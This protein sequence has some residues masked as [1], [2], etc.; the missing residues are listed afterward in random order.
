[1]A[2]FN[3]TDLLVFVDGNAVAHSN[4]CTITINQNQVDATDKDSS[5]WDEFI[6]GQR[7]WTVDVDGLV[8]YSTSVNANE[9]FDDAITA[10]ASVT[11]IFSTAVSGARYYSGSANVASLTETGDLDAPASFSVSF[12][13]TGALT[14]ADS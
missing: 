2:K 11:L 12:Q 4:T 8:D 6:N 7:N 14:R 1:M 3:G 13:G 10:N 5:R 9:L